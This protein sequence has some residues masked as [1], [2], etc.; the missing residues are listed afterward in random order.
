[1][2]K[3]AQKDVSVTSDNSPQQ[4]EP[5]SMSPFGDFERLMES[6]FDRG[7]MPSKRW[8]HPLWERFAAFE[9]GVPKV[10]V[11]DRDS[12]VLVRAEVPGFDNKELDVSVTDG[13][14][15]IKGEHGEET[16]EEEGQ[17]F[18]SE[19]TRNAFTRT[20]ALPS[21]VDADKASA[22]FKNG[23]LELTLPKL[24]KANRRKVEVK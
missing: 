8:E 22:S 9:K 7:L 6:F 11:V 2:A 16:R 17:Y 10:D 18:H 1:M 14:V 5:R 20:V 3:K 13:A 15:T 19:I 4:K 12:E 21:E 23:I 24:K